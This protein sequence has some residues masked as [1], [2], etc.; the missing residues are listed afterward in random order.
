[1]S[2]KSE[3]SKS[4]FCQ[5]LG[6]L[7][8]FME[9]RS[10]MEINL[11]KLENVGNAA[12]TGVLRSGP[13]FGLSGLPYRSAHRL[14]SEDCISRLLCVISFHVFAKGNLVKFRFKFQCF[15]CN[16]QLKLTNTKLGYG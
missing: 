8:K 3:K 16:Q 2:R 6:K 9:M 5:C 10:F 1:M 14:K 12:Q 13:V 15:F 7:F 11:E 4:C